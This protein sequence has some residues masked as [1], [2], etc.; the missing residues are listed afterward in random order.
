M[1]VILKCPACE[2]KYRWDAG[3]ETA[4]EFCPNEDCDWK[5]TRRPDND[6]VM[7][8]LR[9]ARTTANDRVYRQMEEGSEKR[10]HLAAEA[11][12]CSPADMSGLKITNLSDRKDSEI[13]AMP[14][15]NT[16][17]QHMEQM[18]GK[19]GQFGFSNNGSEWA[20]GVSDGSVTINGKVTKGIAPRA[21]ANTLG[22]IQSLHGR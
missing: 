8:F 14:V 9:S 22:R 13:A 3:R 18:N 11:A 6:V 16:V 12:G 7:P 2:T 20:A 5:D 21:G 15:Q 4:P 1:P 10:V 17:T 19:G